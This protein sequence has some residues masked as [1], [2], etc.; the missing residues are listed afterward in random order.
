MVC[1]MLLAGGVD[2]VVSSLPQVSGCGKDAS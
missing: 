2:E 1:G